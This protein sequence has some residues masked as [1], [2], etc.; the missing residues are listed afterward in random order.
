MSKNNTIK[1]EEQALYYTQHDFD[2]LTNLLMK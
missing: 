1:E 2:R